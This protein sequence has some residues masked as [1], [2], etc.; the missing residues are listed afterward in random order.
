[1][2]V[3]GAPYS[4]G[5]VQW[6]GLGKV[7]E[8]AGEIMQIAGK[9]MA[10]GG[11]SEYYDGRDLRRELQNEMADLRAALDYVEDA[12]HLNALAMKARKDE[13]SD[14]FWSWHRQVRGML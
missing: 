10:T 7:V 11:S 8:E 9:L 14:K 5:A 12:N 2:A 4:I 1:M 13:K 3:E 6:P